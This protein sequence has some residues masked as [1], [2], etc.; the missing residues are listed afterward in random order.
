MVYYNKLKRNFNENNSKIYA[1]KEKTAEIET[2]EEGYI[3]KPKKR[4]FF[5]VN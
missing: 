3:D 1:T 5:V 4:T 2:N